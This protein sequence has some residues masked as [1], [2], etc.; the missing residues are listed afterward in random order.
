MSAFEEFVKSVPGT[1][2]GWWRD[3]RLAARV[4]TRLP[5]P[6]PAERGAKVLAARAFPVVGVG[7]GLAAGAGLLVATSLGLHPLASALVALSVAA[8]VTGAMNEDGLA[9][10]ADGVVGGK[11]P[12][13]KLKIMR[14]RRKGTLGILAIVLGVGMRAAVIA[15]LPGPWT[16]AAAL[17]AAGAA[18]RGVLPAVMV[19]LKPLDG[20]GSAAVG[21]PEGKD[22][23]TG[24]LLG[25]ALTLLFLSP[26]AGIAAVLA[27]ALA[28]A[29]LAALCGRQ[30]GGYT[31]NV[32]G[33]VQ[34]ATELAV[35]VAV[36]AVL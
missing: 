32:L 27:A 13:G 12:A 30:I 4:L 5:L 17:V 36:A 9:C 1:L 18:S 22:A 26:L 34:Q 29:A 25:G 2:A 19:R 31:G 21:R 33:A 8:A 23:V 20:D 24:A 10:V 15:G 35:L 14:E 7:V 3:T 28:A 11:S 16:A 6:A